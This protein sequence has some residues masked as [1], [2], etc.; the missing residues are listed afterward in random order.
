MRQPR[1]NAGPARGILRLPG[2]QGSHEHHRVLPRPELRELVAHFWGVSWS[3]ATPELVE[4]LGHPT[5]HL[6][7][8]HGPDGC[9]AEVAGVPLAK[10][11]RKLAGDG[12]VFG[13]K[14]R[15][16]AGRELL[17]GSVHRLT[18]KVLPLSRV[19]PDAEAL[20]ASIFSTPVFP[21]RVAVAERFLMARHSGV[22]PALVVLRDLVEAIA[23]DAELIRVE[24]L[25]D[26]VGVDRR[27]LERRFR[28]AVGVTPKWVIRR[29]RLH[30]ATERLRRGDAL[31]EVAHDLGYADQAHFSR[32]FKAAV[33]TSPAA[34]VKRERS[35]GER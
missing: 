31:I 7:F 18:G 32:D 28:D 13:I 33:G 35:D 30:E 9:R 25:V 14:L 27:T 4:T 23:T 12:W 6:V 15:P 2:E 19:L 1:E 17:G 3:L 24:Q 26:R 21:G 11:S 10:F 16:G 22:S 34:F 8:E 5:V 29:Y 20:A